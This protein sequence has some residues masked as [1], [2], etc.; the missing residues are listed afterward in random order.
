MMLDF[1]RSVIAQALACL[2]TVACLGGCSNSISKQ[3]LNDR[4]VANPSLAT[5]NLAA[6]P[7]DVL[8]QAIPDQ[9]PA[10]VEETPLPSDVPTLTDLST[11]PVEGIDAPKVGLSIDED[12]ATNKISNSVR[13][14]G[15]RNADGVDLANSNG[16]LCSGVE[17]DASAKNQIKVACSDGRVAVVKLAAGNEAQLMF[18]DGST[19]LVLLDE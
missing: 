12:L 1:N 8:Q 18:R 5:N 15:K 6:P 9:N 3:L 11:R 2:V 16:A 19:E 17:R 10:F 13:W 7:A 14:R 4:P